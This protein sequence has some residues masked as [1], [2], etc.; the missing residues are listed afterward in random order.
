MQLPEADRHTH[1]KD[2]LEGQLAILMGGRVAEE[3]FT[4]RITSGAGNDID[5]ATGIAR[6][7]VCEFGM[8]SF[9]PI[10]FRRAGAPWEDDGG[11]GFSEATARR[12]DEEIRDLV[13]R[14]YETARRLIGRHREAVEALAEELLQVES[15]DADAVRALLAGRADRIE[16]AARSIAD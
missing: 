6:R 15:L 8:S 2:Y 7:M 4:G 16:V 11:A 3:V 5:R 13:M 9:G 1:S 14:G 12:V 10:A